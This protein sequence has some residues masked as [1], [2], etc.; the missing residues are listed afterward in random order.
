[1]LGLVNLGLLL[2]QKRGSLRWRDVKH[3]V[4]SRE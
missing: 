3:L 4:P 1:V 2:L